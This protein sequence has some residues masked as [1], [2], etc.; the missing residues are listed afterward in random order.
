[1]KLAILERAVDYVVLDDYYTP[2]MNQVLEPVLE[3]AGYWQD[4]QQTV[5]LGNGDPIR[6][7]VFL[8]PVESVQR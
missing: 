7:R 5:E 2:E 6:V 3:A 1:M 8:P 4:F